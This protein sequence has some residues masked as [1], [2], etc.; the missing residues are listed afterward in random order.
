L[1]EEYRYSSVIDYSG[2][3][4]IL[5]VEVIGKQREIK[6]IIRFKILIIK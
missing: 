4:G 1:P 6:I 5:K 2:G 3:K